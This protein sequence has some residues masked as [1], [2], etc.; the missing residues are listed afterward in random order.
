MSKNGFFLVLDGID[1]C[2]KSSQ[3]RMVSKYFKDKGYKT[4]ITAEPTNMEIGKILRKSLK[5]EHTPTALDALLFA[6]DRIDHCIHEIIPL[7]EK[8]YLV[9][10]D[11]YRD[12]SYIY[13]TIQGKKRD[14]DI[15]MDWV[16]T[17]NNKSLNPDL[18]IILDLKPEIALNRRIKENS[19]NR[20]EMEKFEKLEFQKQ[21][22]FLFQKLTKENQENPKDPHISIKGNRTKKEIFENILGILRKKKIKN[23]LSKK[24]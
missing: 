5:N 2:G 3:S 6:A 8:G 10:S 16:K 18:T 12:S 4:H 17:I 9:I 23:Q 13:Q 11:R 22:R 14:E 19:E 15:T 21:V 24:K 1:G 20:Q 7:L